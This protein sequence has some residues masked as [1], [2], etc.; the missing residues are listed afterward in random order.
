[1]RARTAVLGLGTAVAVGAVAALRADQRW[2]RA[3]DS[4][5]PGDL[6]LPNGQALTVTTEDGAELVGS[7]S[8]QGPLVK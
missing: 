8:G 6:D 5:R 1:M 7:V 3:E 2:A 4:L